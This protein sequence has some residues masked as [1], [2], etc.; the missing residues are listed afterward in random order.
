MAVEILPAILAS[1]K[2][3]FIKKL[4]S[5]SSC[6]KRIHLDIADGVFV[7]NRTVD[8]IAEVSDSGF[9]GFWDVHLMVAN[10][11]EVARKWFKIAEVGTIFLHSSTIS[12]KDF[13][14]LSNEARLL[15]FDL[16]IVFD[17]DAD[18]N[19]LAEYISIADIIQCMTVKPGFYGGDFCP[20][21]LGLAK[22][23]SIKYPRKKIIIDGAMN[24]ERIVLA[25]KAGAS[26]IISG[27]Y[28]MNKDNPC[29]ALLELRNQL[30]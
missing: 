18:Y 25:I 6:A 11:I 13:A 7:N 1:T 15:G 2:D 20:Q 12:P 22:Q 26:E 17:V 27:G 10:P 29:Q 28:I 21:G 30:L 19:K 5:V 23:I 14:S 8:G 3:D 16:G 9:D 24:P 4:G